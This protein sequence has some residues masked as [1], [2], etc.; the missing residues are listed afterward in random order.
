METNERNKRI[1][2]E[3]SKVFGKENVS[4]RGDR[5]TAYG[6]VNIKIK[7]NSPPDVN[8][9][10]YYEKSREIENKVW[11]V[12]RNTNLDKELGRY[13]DDMGFKHTEALVF[14]RFE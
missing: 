4:V 8:S 7:S 5:G 14:V 6:W 2:K 9:D 3:L 12:L 13:Y 1:K 10:D 11:E